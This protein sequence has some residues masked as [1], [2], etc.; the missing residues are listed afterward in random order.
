MNKYE[1]LNILSKS[2]KNVPKEERDNAI[3]FY[4][5]Y[6]ADAKDEQEAINSLP[7]PKKIAVKIIM[8]TGEV[9]GGISLSTMILAVCSAPITLPLAIALISVVFALAIVVITLIF[10]P[11]IVFASFVLSSIPL[12]IG[13]IPAFLHN[14]QTGLAFLGMAGGFL[15]LGLLG[16]IGFHILAKKILGGFKKL[17]LKIWKRSSKNEE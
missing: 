2:L 17:V 12:T 1:F 13:V 11:Y 16:L 6:F 3:N 5:E 15:S 4:E 9:K 8:E 7:H 14:F 10:V